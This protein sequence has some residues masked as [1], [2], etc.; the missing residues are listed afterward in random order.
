MLKPLKFATA[1]AAL[2]VFT[3]APP[4]ASADE[5]DV[6]LKVLV[7]K[8]ILTET[9]A[10]AVK[11]EV[12]KEKAKEPKVVA[13]SAAPGAVTSG[14]L[15]SKIDISKSIEKVKLYGNI[16]LRYQY[17]DKDPQLFLPDGSRN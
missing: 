5:N 13:K 8:G 10:A 3:A 9:E 12:A 2:A 16:R 11:S 1:M 17:E 15:D 7:R 4:A 14:G 6:L